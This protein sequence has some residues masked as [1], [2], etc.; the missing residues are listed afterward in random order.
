MSIYDNYRDRKYARFKTLI[1]TI[2]GE[3]VKNINRIPLKLYFYAFI[4]LI[5]ISF[6]FYF[7]NHPAILI[8]TE[9]S[10]IDD[11]T[12]NQ[13]GLY[14]KVEFLDRSKLQE[15]TFTLKVNYSNN[16]ENLEV[17]IPQY[18]TDLLGSEIYLGAKY[19]EHNDAETYQFIHEAEIIL[20][21][22]QVS[23]EEIKKLLQEGNIL[24]TWDR[25]GKREQQTYNIGETVLYTKQ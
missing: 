23:R 1:K 5:I 15:L 16:V 9:I 24:L 3:N 4:G 6:Y 18:F 13:L 14:D 17:N 20:F 8:R 12:Y 10:P 19:K 25:K 2:V 22:G 7:Q 21:T 11:M